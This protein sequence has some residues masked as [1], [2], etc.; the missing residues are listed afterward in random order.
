MTWQGRR[1]GGV[2]REKQNIRTYRSSHWDCSS[3]WDVFRNNKMLMRISSYITAV[4]LIA[5][6]YI[7][8]IIV[9]KLGS[10]HKTRCIV[11]VWHSHSTPMQLC[12]VSPPSPPTAFSL[13]RYTRRNTV[14]QAKSSHTNY[15]SPTR[16]SGGC[17]WKDDAESAHRAWRCPRQSNFKSARA[18]LG[19]R[20]LI[21]G[22]WCLQNAAHLSQCRTLDV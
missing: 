6:D 12:F 2:R 19:C 4:S 20:L 17:N 15:L 14:R 1:Q 16:P 8:K 18:L 10:P 13:G 11:L 3:L 5:I 7:V 21:M 9:W 22:I